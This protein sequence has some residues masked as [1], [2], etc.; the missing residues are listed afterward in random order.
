[1]EQVE[2]D[3]A[4]QDTGSADAGG[5]NEA[6][7][8][9]PAE[10]MEAPVEE[11]P[12][13][14]AAFEEAPVEE[15]PVEE[16]PVEE[17][18]VED[19]AVEEVPVEEVPV[20]DTAMADEEIPEGDFG[21]ADEPVTVDPSEDQGPE[22]VNNGTFV[23]DKLASPTSQGNSA[24]NTE[25]TGDAEETVEPFE[26]GEGFEDAANEAV[27]DALG[28][29]QEKF[30]ALANDANDSGEFDGISQAVSGR[31]FADL[32]EQEQTTLKKTLTDIGNEQAAL[33]GTIA[34]TASAEDIASGNVS[35]EGVVLGNDVNAAL[36]PGKDGEKDTAA[37]S[38]R[39]FNTDGTPK[40]K[41]ALASAANEEV[42]E[43]I[44]RLFKD[45]DSLVAEGDLGA[46]LSTLVSGDKKTA[47]AKDTPELF[48]AKTEDSTTAL[49]D[50]KSLSA[51]AQQDIP[52]TE[53]E[54]TAGQR[55]SANDA[56]AGNRRDV[57]DKLQGAL[58]GVQDLAQELGGRSYGSGHLVANSNSAV[59]DFGK[60]VGQA[61]SDMMRLAT[62]SG[63]VA[64][65]M[66]AA[67]SAEI[68]EAELKG[69]FNQVFSDGGINPDSIGKNLES[70]ANNAAKPV[71]SMINNASSQFRDL[72]SKE[73]LNEALN[74]LGIVAGTL[75]DGIGGVLNVAK[76]FKTL[77][78]SPS[79]SVDTLKDANTIIEAP[80]GAATTA[81]RRGNGVITA[82]DLR[83]GVA[84]TGVD[85]SKLRGSP[86]G[87][88]SL[89]NGG[90]KSAMGNIRGS[91]AN[92]V[93][94]NKWGSSVATEPSPN[95]AQAWIDQL[96]NNS[97]S[98][99]AI[100]QLRSG[101]RGNKSEVLE[102]K[103]PSF[104]G[105]FGSENKKALSRV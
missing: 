4:V 49:V 23:E 102:Y 94:T 105:P 63:R 44:G 65:A 2:G 75:D 33:T 9:P 12:V 52:A 17:A 16:A 6:Q 95:S 36:I 28:T 38:E 58:E 19:T 32:T 77:R 80:L 90:M 70:F 89:R 73:K 11:A 64:D 78:A 55:D 50:G 76:S 25:E 67:K 104:L 14:E 5:G 30:S 84:P 13:E 47:N 60:G 35:D 39:L 74:T 100:K 48:K 59:V 1:M 42:G 85:G 51:A 93:Q 87:A 82:N 79:A 96:G 72:K 66:K 40:D 98:I 8:M 56:I 29:S 22:W 10:S 61:A 68:P 45:S 83:K 92:A 53:F 18:P 97:S 71:V 34:K 26:R 31:D 103:A 101:A 69:V 62:T 21:P 7:S 46:R 43:S 3:V 20:E 24:S 54:P 15:A 99:Y 41:D 37:F 57:K 88:N 86:A 27:T 91:L 81:W